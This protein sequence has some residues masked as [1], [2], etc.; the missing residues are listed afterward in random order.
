MK[1]QY[2]A[3]VALLLAAN[4]FSQNI[5]TT[6]GTLGANRTVSLDNKFLNFNSTTAGGNLYINGTSGNVGIGNTAPSEKLE[7]SGVIK[8]KNLLAT[9]TATSASS[10]ANN[11]AWYKNAYVLGA[12]YEMTDAAMAGSTRRMINFYDKH[13]WSPAYPVGNDGFEFSIV[14]R[15]NKDRMVFQGNKSGGSSNGQSTFA[16]NDKNGSENFKIIDDGNSNINIQMGKAT[17]R[18]II[19]GYSNYAPGL[20]HKFIV[21]N[22]SA[23]IEGNILTNANVGIGTST[24][25]DGA[26]TFRLSVD[27]NIRA[28]RVKVYT[29]WADYVFEKNYDLPTLAEVEQHILNN[30]H[31]K[32]IPSAKEVEANGIELGEMNKLLLQKVEELTLYV[33]NLNKELEKVK[34]QL[35]DKK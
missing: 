22:G 12:G 13:G 4:S 35:N 33:I 10:F 27:G 5:Y 28:K 17:S 6:D 9:N 25:T 8:S 3:F 20:A 15:A 26:D 23:L 29:T 31:L 30:G 34:T 14:D 24:F 16:V 2:Y 1:K 11:L 32:D 7:V 21:Q 19:G 18:F